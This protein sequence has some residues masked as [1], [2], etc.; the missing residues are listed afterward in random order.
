MPQNSS[1]IVTPEPGGL[2]LARERAGLSKRRL[3]Q[4]AGVSRAT[5]SAYE[6][7]AQPELT[8][9]FVR[10]A[11]A[12][13]AARY[14]NGGDPSVA[15]AVRMDEL[16]GRFGELLGILASLARVQADLIDGGAR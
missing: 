5:L 4:A 8:P 16:E 15:P 12:I 3:A 10:I 14:G 9:T 13:D 7:K 1:T 2:R 11:N 6:A